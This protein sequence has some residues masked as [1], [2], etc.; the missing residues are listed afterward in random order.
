MRIF[1][2]VRMYISLS[3][4]I[5]TYIHACIHIHLYIHVHTYMYIHIER[6][7]YTNAC[8]YMYIYIHGHTHMIYTTLNF[9]TELSSFG[10]APIL[11]RCCRSG[12]T[13]ANV[14]GRSLS[15]ASDFLCPSKT[16]KQ[17]WHRLYQKVQ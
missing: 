5:Y 2:Y 8:V 17:L 10:L 7:I 16:G 4:Y 12:K 9:R 1:T 11:R 14:G 13:P 6:Y 3:I 15:G